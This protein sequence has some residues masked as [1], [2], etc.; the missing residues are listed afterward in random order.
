MPGANHWQA[1]APSA[2][3]LVPPPTKHPSCTCKQSGRQG[4]QAHK[5]HDAGVAH[6][7]HHRCLVLQLLH[8]HGWQLQPLAGEVICTWRWQ[9][10]VVGGSRAWVR[11]RS[12]QAPIHADRHSFSA[13]TSVDQHLHSHLAWVGAGVGGWVGG[14]QGGEATTIPTNTPY[15]STHPTHLSTTTYPPTH[16]PPQTCVSCHFAR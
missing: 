9:A 4:T 6:A 13:R 1:T 15:P 7:A 10:A 11:L 2:A 16:T 12:K 3:T 14:R 5:L 8:G